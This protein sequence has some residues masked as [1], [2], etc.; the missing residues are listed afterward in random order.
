MP[1]PALGSAIQ[2]RVSRRWHCRIR[3]P[4]RSNWGGGAGDGGRR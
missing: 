4:E 2:Y 1:S 3:R